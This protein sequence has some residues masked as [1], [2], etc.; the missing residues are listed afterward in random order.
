MEQQHAKMQTRG[1]QPVMLEGITMAGDL[2][3]LMLE[4]QV[5][6]RFRNQHRK[7][8]EVAYT[9]PLP[10]G[11]VLLG[12]DV[13]LG[14]KRLGGAVVEK[15]QAEA[16]YEEALS[17][18]NT[19]IMLEKNHDHSYTLNLG[20]LAACEACVVTL[21]YAQLL[22]FAG[23][24]RTLR[25]LLPTVI[26][27]RYGDA[28]HDGGLQPHQAPE[29]DLLA[30]YPFDLTLR[31]HGTMA[32]ARVSSPTHPIAVGNSA[33]SVLSVTLGRRGSLDRDF[34][35]TI[36]ALADSSVAALAADAV[37]PGHCVALASFCPQV[38]AGAPTALSLKLLVDCSGSMAG[39]SLA[40][41]R[42]AL[43]S[44]VG[45]MADGDRFSLSRFGSTVEHRSR[46]LW[47]AGERTRLA[48]QRWVGALEADLGGTEMEDALRSTFALAQGGGCDVLLLTDGEIQAIDSAEALVRGAGH[49]LFVVA[50]GSSPAESHLRRLADASGGACDFVAP[51]EAVEPAVLRMF[52]RLRS[53]RLADVRVVW[54]DAAP[55]VWASTPGTAVFDGDT[56]NVFALFATQPAGT[57]RLQG[58]WPGRPPSQD[59]GSVSLNVPLQPGDGL[60]RLAATARIAAIE[61]GADFVLSREI[62]ALAVNYRLVTPHTSF[63]LV[64]ERADGD[65]A[66]EMPD[67]HKVVQMTAA[68]WGGSGSAVVR[69]HGNYFESRVT[70]YQTPSTLDWSDADA[71]MFS[72]SPASPQ[73]KKSPSAPSVW[74]MK[75]SPVA[76]DLYPSGFDAIMTP[77]FLQ[78]L[79]PDRTN[80]AFWASGDGY[81]GWTPEGLGEWLRVSP[82]NN[83]PNSYAGLSAMGLGKAVVEWLEF[84]V[85]HSQP[86]AA[87]VRTFLHVMSRRE[88]YAS[89][90]APPSGLLGGLKAL[91]HNVLRS[92]GGQSRDTAGIDPQL[93][94]RMAVLVTGPAQTWPE[95]VFAMDEA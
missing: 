21:R 42:R 32:R 81:E 51:G 52:S 91:V 70:E 92:S 85:G 43:Q 27:P 76:R 54:P 63:L 17:E 74:C 79:E 48:A 47:K 56:V 68:G 26:A 41:A 24:G 30:L 45:Q 95:A 13:L 80:P 15:K 46:A 29:H 37:L 86:E 67:L 87:V 23:A 60:S 36:D 94:Q 55:P 88:M 12:V 18:G 90:A 65:K 53:P 50:I 40:A 22:Q 83:W 5:E 77:P 16:Q 9:F 3:G 2:R 1:G 82:V 75:R 4:M 72:R 89:L 66:G 33:D 28:M 25:L 78:S 71:P 93:A 8:V 69:D 11:A 61:S 31:L 38:P 34:V 57:V 39:D 62:V 59:I 6:Q 35:L 20:N 44:I 58:Q 7:N 64:H 84:T 49:R 14:H 73:T 10:W 19:A